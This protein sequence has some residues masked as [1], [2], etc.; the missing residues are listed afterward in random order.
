MGIFAASKR[1]EMGGDLK[2]ASIITKVFSQI[3]SF[4]LCLNIY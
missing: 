3:E 1:D 2:R 4:L